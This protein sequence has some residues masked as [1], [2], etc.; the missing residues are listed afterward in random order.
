MHVCVAAKVSKTMRAH[1][2]LSSYGNIAMSTKR[3]PFS[4]C[5]S[6]FTW[7]TC[8]CVPN[9]LLV[10]LR[11]GS[12]ECSL[13]V[14]RITPVALNFEHITDM[15]AFFVRETCN[16]VLASWR[17]PRSVDGICVLMLVQL[18]VNPGI[19]W[20]TNMMIWNGIRNCTHNREKTM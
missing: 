10:A 6:S 2:S 11:R 3:L 8:G 19:S 12:I 16:A 20:K 7:R 18:D 4:G 13:F 14:Y 17:T 1:Q 9:V 15:F 5:P